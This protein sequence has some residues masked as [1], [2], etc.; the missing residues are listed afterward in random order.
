MLPEV[1]LA[2]SSPNFPIALELEAFLAAP[3]PA[4]ITTSQFLPLLEIPSAFNSL[5]ILSKLERIA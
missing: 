4:K 3:L 5:A 2:K 1:L